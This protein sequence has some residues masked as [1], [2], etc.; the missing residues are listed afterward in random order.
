M[1]FAAQVQMNWLPAVSGHM[2]LRPGLLHV[3]EVDSDNPCLPIDFVYS[4]TDTA[5]LE[6]TNNKLRVW[7]SDVL[8]TR[9]AVA[10]TVAD[11]NMSGSGSTWTKTDT[12]AGCTTTV[13]GGV[14]T[15]TASARGGLSRIKQTLTIASGDQNKEHAL[16]IVVTDGPVTIRV[17]SSDGLQDYMTSA[18]IDTGTHSLVFTPTA[19]SA[20]LQIDS[21]DTWAKT[22]TSVNIEAAGIVSIPT[23]WS[24]AQLPT[25]RWSQSGDI[26][27]VAQ[28]GAQQYKIER[29]G[30]RPG[31]RGWSVVLY[32]STSG[33]FLNLPTINNCVMTPSVYEG[34]GTLSSSLPFFQPGHVGALFQLFTPGQNNGCALGAQGAFSDPV[35][36]S[37]T[38]PTRK[39]YWTLSG[40]WVGTVSLQLSLVGPT[41][42]FAFVG[43]VTSNGTTLYDDTSSFYQDNVVVWLR[44]GFVNPGDYVSGAATVLWGNGSGGTAGTTAAGAP[45][46]GGQYGL[47]RVTGYTSPTQV[48]IEVLSQGALN[49]G[50][51]FSSLLGTTNWLESAWSGVQGWPTSVGFH[52][53]RLGWF[54]AVNFPMTLS[55]SNNYTGYASIDMYGNALGDAGVILASFGEGPSDRV[56]WAL[57]LQRLLL[58]REQ[59]VASV[60][61]SSFDT[62]L[63]PSD[64][65]VK[66]CSQ[67]G[68]ARLPAIKVG[69]RGIFVQESG[70]KVYELSY[71]AQASDYVDADLTRLNHDIGRPGFTDIAKATQPDTIIYLPRADGEVACLLYDPNDEVQAWWRMM[72]MGVVE[73]VRVLPNFLGGLDSFVYFIV[74]RTINGVTRR[75]IEKLAQRSDCVGGLANHQLDCAVVYSGSPV[76]SVTASW[77]LNT[78]VLVWADGAY[79]GTATAD[80]SGVITMPDGLTHSNIVAGLGGSI[81]SYSGAASGVMTGLAAFNGIPGE[82]FAD[83]QPSGRMVY[84]GTLTP[85]GGQVTLPNGIEVKQIVAFFGYM[86]PFMSAKLAYGARMGSPLTMKKKVDHLGLCMFDT[87]ATG[88]Q[89]G[90]RF[91]T[92]DPL[93][94]YEDNAE[95]ST[96]GVWSEYDEP[97]ITVPGEWDSDARLCLLAQAPFPCK[98]GGLVIGMGTNE[99]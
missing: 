19:G 94:A 57:P 28:Y 78:T 46:A 29:R 88:V 60:R 90:Q 51:A 30:A 65:S 45:S 4:K 13:T 63:T 84:V 93:P 9:V 48:N 85:S 50:G 56:N 83:Q 16:R 75:F 25:L 5:L 96:A 10:T 99:S 40:T 44:L 20:F 32:K 27:Y 34:N 86:A 81:A 41:S 49:G 42:G 89:F 12:T 33:P 39:I 70:A 47:C 58:G 69:P 3:G 72:T 98:V 7:I 64:F 21:T 26:L 59:S 79:I 52:E 2:G 87:A 54:S 55:Q 8:L 17:G 53:G 36:I 35:R 1:Q 77:L 23:P 11:P 80:G 74:K 97:M 95:V 24:T 37:G 31:A 18:A 73:N 76:S 22:L 61:S 6:L 92:L 62:P 15:L 67:Q 82:F 71:V 38:G 43:S 14:A 66:D 68:A 91:D